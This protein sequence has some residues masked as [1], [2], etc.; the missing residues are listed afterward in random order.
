MRRYW[1][2][3][4]DIFGISFTALSA[5]LAL[6][7]VSGSIYA[8]VSLGLA[9][10]FG[11]MG[12]INFAHGAFYMLGAVLTWA[13][14]N[15]LGLSYWP[16]LLICPIMVGCTAFFVERFGL[17]Y[18]YTVDPLYC[19]LFTL[20]FSLVTKGILSKIYGTVGFPYNVPAQLTG[21]VNLGFMY[22]PLYRVWTL[23]V[24]LVICGGIFILI[25]KTRLGSILRAA[26]EN[27]TLTQA[28]GHNVPKLRS[29]IF[30][31][32]G[33]LAGFAGVMASPILQIGP[34]M[35]DDLII[36]VF[37]IVVIGGMGSLGGTIISGYLLGMVEAIAKIWVPEASSVAIFIFMSVVLIL[38]PQGLFGKE[39]T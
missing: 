35:G 12:V 25:E 30:V 27:S 22:M 19:F 2:F 23:V 8:M 15:Y 1:G 28:L 24:S 26:S 37:A 34:L 5:Q 38:K 20:G 6:G 33:A 3:K 10:I 29:L 39:S 13:I 16:A 11:L 36:I 14:M 18:L 21:A 7:L 17:K 4:I 32:G 31:L 9:I